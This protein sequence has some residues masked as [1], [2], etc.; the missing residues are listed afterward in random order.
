MKNILHKLFASFWFRNGFFSI[1]QRFSVVLV[2][3]FS[4]LLLVRSFSMEQIGVWTNFLIITSTFEVIKNGL[5]KNPLIKFLHDYPK[6]FS[7]PIQSSSLYLN[8]FVTL[9]ILGLLI[10]FSDFLENIL[11]APNLSLLLKYYFISAIF[12]IPFSHIE[13]LLQ[14]KFRFEELLKMYSIRQGTFLL[15]ILV[16]LV[17]NY[18]TFTLLN[19]VFFQA[20]GIFFSTVVGALAVKDA[21]NFSLKIS[22]PWWKRSWQYGKF[23]MATNLSSIIFRS[24]DQLMTSMFISVEA[25]A[26]YNAAVRIS[27]LIDLP[28]T[29]IAEILFPKSV[30]S[31]KSEGKKSTRNLY[32]KAVAAILIFVLPV[33]I[34][35]FIFPDTILAIIAGEDYI[36]AAA[37]LQIT[38]VYGLFLPFMKQSGMVLDS[39][40]YAK[41]N[42]RINFFLTLFNILINYY[43]ITTF[44][45]LGAAYGSLSTYFLGFVLCQF[46]LNKYIGVNTLRIV[47]IIPSLIGTMGQKASVKFKT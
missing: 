14:S 36:A 34:G 39:I 44:G 2:G 43:M 6:K 17:Q 8:F 26:L 27:N 20:A 42:F 1:S 13:F 15:L 29:S 47:K 3:L 10:P 40:G 22:L 41:I 12:L 11:N 28:S 9:V 45:L 30:I 21:L 31:N 35:I 23:T 46:I 18:F 33:S 38:V 7:L 16:A 32:E 19:L 25:A 37:I 24:T 4:Y 5:L